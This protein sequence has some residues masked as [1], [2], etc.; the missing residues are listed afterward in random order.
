MLIRFTEIVKVSAVKQGDD[1]LGYRC[2]SVSAHVNLEAID[3]VRLT[4]GI[5]KVSDTGQAEH[6]G[7]IYE[8]TDRHGVKYL[9][10]VLAEANGTL[11]TL[12]NLGS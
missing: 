3:S 4:N 5:T 11:T 9:I 7:S 6:Y 8:L 10:D 1:V 2:K 12:L